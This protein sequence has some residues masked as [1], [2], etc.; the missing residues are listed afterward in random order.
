VAGR[1]FD[2]DGADHARALV[3]VGIAVLAIQRAVSGKRAGPVTLTVL[4][5]AI[6][7]M[8]AFAIVA[9]R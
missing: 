1:R 3:P 9:T 8:T 5:C 2:T 7:A 6:K 4:A